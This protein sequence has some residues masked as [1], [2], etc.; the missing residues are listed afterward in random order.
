M[1]TLSFL[2][3]KEF[4]QIFR[5]PT[6]LRMILAL[7]I[8]QLTVLPLAAD[9]EI[10]NI[11]LVVVDQDRSTF[12]RDLVSKITASGY[13]ILVDYNNNALQSM[14]YIESDE[15]DVVLEI[16][17]NFEKNLVREGNEQLF[18]A[19]NAI[20]GT[21]ANVGGA[22]LSQ[23]IGSF[24]QEIRVEWMQKGSAKK[25]PMLEIAAINWFNPLLNYQF[26]MVPGILVVLVTMIGAYMCAL[27]IVKEKEAGTIEQINVTPI[28]KH[29]FILGKLIPFWMIGVFVFSV[30]LFVVGRLVYG[31]I[32]VGSLVLLYAYLS[33]YLIAVLGIGLLVSTYSNTQQQAM[34]LA[35]FLMMIFILMSGLFTS[36]D[37]MPPWAK[38]ITQLNPVTYFIEVVRMIIMKGSEFRHILHHFLI[39]TGFALFFNTW[40]VLNYSKTS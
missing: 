37:S 38:F 26:F 17:H 24:N 2:L 4:R 34:S 15:A 35:F 31:I 12:S 14:E 19:I 11:N 9:F 23:L 8:I 27:N 20:N 1:K 16:P 13:F 5:N 29:H 30:G 18:L 33:L 39:M 10:K 40:A 6:L 25:T 32:P 28:K 21:K 3:Q 22:Y 36:I 7:P